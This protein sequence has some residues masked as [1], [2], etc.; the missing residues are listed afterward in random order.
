MLSRARLFAILWTAVC[1]AP[2]ST[3]FSS[4]EYWSGLPFPFPATCTYT[5]TKKSYPNF[6]RNVNASKQY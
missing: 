2:L 3:G 5:V 6:Q 4:Q 1:Q